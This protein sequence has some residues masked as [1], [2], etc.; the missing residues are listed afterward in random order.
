MK[1]TYILINKV[2]VDIKYNVLTC[3]SSLHS[4]DHICSSMRKQLRQISCLW[5]VTNSHSYQ[6]KLD[7]ASLLCC[8]NKLYFAAS[9]NGNTK[10]YKVYNFSYVTCWSICDCKIFDQWLFLSETLDHS[11]F[12]GSKFK[13]QL[14][15]LYS[16]FVDFCSS[17]VNLIPWLTALIVWFIS[18]PGHKR[19]N[20][21]LT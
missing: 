4:L 1:I 11:I 16:R 20:R 5:T 14:C 17:E 9:F 3:N 18:D 8:Y 7:H 6:R 2:P 15:V 21:G 19:F 12:S 10:M 13:L